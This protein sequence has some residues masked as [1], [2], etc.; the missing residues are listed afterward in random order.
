[1]PD[2]QRNEQLPAAEF[3]DI[4]K[5][6]N[7]TSVGMK[8]GQQEFEGCLDNPQWRSKIDFNSTA[9][10]S[11]IYKDTHGRY[12]FRTA[13]WKESL[14][15]LWTSIADALAS[16]FA[17]SLPE[18]VRKSLDSS[19]GRKYCLWTAKETDDPRLQGTDQL[20]ELIEFLNTS[21]TWDDAQARYA[22]RLQDKPEHASLG[23]NVTSLTSHCATVGKLARI[24][25]ELEDVPVRW[26]EKWK[27][28]AELKLDAIKLTVAHLSV[29]VKQ[30]PYRIAEWNVFAQR[31]QTL[32][33]ITRRFPD[34]VLGVNG[35]ELF[36]VSLAESDVLDRIS[37]E[38]EAHGFQIAGRV[39][40]AVSA[41]ELTGKI[42]KRLLEV[43]PPEEVALYSAVPDETIALP[44]CEVCQAAHADHRWPADSLALRDDLSERAMNAIAEIP[45]RSLDA[46][47]FHPGDWEIVRPWVE[48]E[49]EEELC[50]RCFALR[51][52]ATKL[53]KLRGWIG[54]SVAWIH[55][56]ADLETLRQSLV[57]LQCAYLRANLGDKPQAVLD[58]LPTVFAAWPLVADFLADHRAFLSRLGAQWEALVG[59]EAVET[60]DENLW[61]LRLEDRQQP[62]GILESYARLFHEH[63]P[64][65]CDGD[66]HSPIRFAISISPHKH[67]FFSHW[68]FLENPAAEVAVQAVGAGTAF[69]RVRELASAIEA[70]RKAPPHALKRLAGIAK[71]SMALSN[72]ALRDLQAGVAPE[73]AA[74]RGIAERRIDAASLALLSNFIER[75]SHGPHEH[76]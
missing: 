29:A 69:F 31:R 17:R 13:Q 75:D 28:E 36:L 53:L 55:V 49:R 32:D 43:L 15:W 70:V 2:T 60:V 4:G 71:T 7:W 59:R 52:G 64:K 51:R 62:L 47:Q 72:L 39:A 33:A 74:L 12:E 63:F 22:H 58:A 50:A 8:S 16:G 23:V 18:N 42:G 56:R 57:S 44:L 54:S 14:D 48:E 46:S 21:P 24:L 27:S 65:L 3:H 35:S 19:E 26:D 68:R 5:I 61:C 25:S 41:S 37:G 34:N 40:A 10:R 11:I 30:R 20:N 1:M 38:I 9:W 76:D 67:P 73:L 6:F 45:W 66:L